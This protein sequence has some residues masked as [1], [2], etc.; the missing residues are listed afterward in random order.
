[1]NRGRSAWGFSGN[2]I[3]DTVLAQLRQDIT[4]DDKRQLQRDLSYEP[5]WMRPAIHKI[6]MPQAA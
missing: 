1:M 4:N 2:Q 6:T 5:T 3:N